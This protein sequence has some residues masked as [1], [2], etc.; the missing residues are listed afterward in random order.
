M[1]V[2][3]VVLA[4]AH[5]LAPAL[6][7]GR[8]PQPTLLLGPFGSWLFANVQLLNGDQTDAPS[9]PVA[10][11]FLLVAGIRLIVPLI[12]GVTVAVRRLHD[13]NLSGWWVLLA[14]VPPGPFV[15]LLLAARGP[16]P[17]GARDL[18]AWITR[19]QAEYPTRPD[20]RGRTGGRRGRMCSGTTPSPA[21]F[22]RPL[23]RRRSPRR[24]GRSSRRRPTRAAPLRRARGSTSPVDPQPTTKT[25]MSHTAAQ[26]VRRRAEP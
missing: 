16:R 3:I 22:T 8:T 6:I 12:P 15:L 7:S 26:Y 5:L 20:Y 11:F 1:L 18:D 14:L 13:S 10:A 4:S 21:G 23:A 2:N 17:E 19:G 25:G 24:C 9:S